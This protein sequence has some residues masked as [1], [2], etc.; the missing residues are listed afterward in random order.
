MIARRVIVRGRV[1]GV[2][3][4]ESTVQTALA[5][6]CV[7]WV[8]NLHDGTV[9]AWIQGDPSAVERVVTWCRHGPPRAEVSGVEEH[10]VPLDAALVSFN[11][12]RSD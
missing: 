3:Y 10:E 8:R 7:G 1:Q 4:R 12:R 9:E 5:E 6:R 2:F 11:R